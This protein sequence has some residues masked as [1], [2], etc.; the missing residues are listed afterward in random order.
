MLTLTQ[1][2]IDRLTL[3]TYDGFEPPVFVYWNLHRACWSLR[4][5]RGHNAGRV[6]AHASL[7]ALAAVEPKVSAA[8]R[9]RVR[10]EN[11]KN[12]HAGLIGV[13]DLSDSVGM[14]LDLPPC[15][16]RITYDPYTHDGFIY[17]ANGQPFRAA[18]FAVLQTVN[19][20]ARVNVSKD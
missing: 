19:N 9:A 4:A 18:R 16:A 10:R 17:S 2:G 6:I 3:D 11:R 7:L 12:V 1:A 14:T 13:V 5:M 8:G 15:D 20:R